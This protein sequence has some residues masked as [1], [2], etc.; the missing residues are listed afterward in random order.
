MSQALLLFTMLILLFV[1]LFVGWLVVTWVWEYIFV[2]EPYQDPEPPGTAGF[3]LAP[4]TRRAWL[5]SY[6]A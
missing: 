1:A 6:R 4:L 3:L 2:I 5:A